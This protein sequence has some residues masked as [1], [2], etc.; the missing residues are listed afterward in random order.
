M[1]NW[2]KF[3]IKRACTLLYLKKEY[4]VLDVLNILKELDEEILI[5][6]C[7]LHTLNIVN[8]KLL[9]AN[10][11]NRLEKIMVVEQNEK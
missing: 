2:G 1:V 11:T 4:Y 9:T 6:K 8:S 3:R 5:T 10:Y 7:A